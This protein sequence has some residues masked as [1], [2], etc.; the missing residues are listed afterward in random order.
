M[1]HNKSNYQPPLVSI[2][3]IKVGVFCSSYRLTTVD[4]NYINGDWEE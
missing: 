4:S 1:E 2:V 3:E